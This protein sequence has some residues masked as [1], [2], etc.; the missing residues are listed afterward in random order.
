MPF[1]SIITVTLN[2]LEGLQTTHDSLQKQGFSDFE[3][4]ICD[5]GSTDGTLEFLDTTN[6][7]R[8]SKNDLGIYDAMNK[9]LNAAN[10][11]YLLFL[12]A[13]DALAS[14]TVLQTLHNHSNNA[15]FLYGDA[16]EEVNGVLNTKNAK[17]HKTIKTGMF[18]HHQA[19]LY[20]REALN[21]LTYNTTYQIAADYDFT[22]RFLQ[23]TQN[24][25]KIREA[26]C[27]FESGGISQTKASLGRKEQFQIRKNLKLCSPLENFTITALQAVMWQLRTMFPGFYWRW[28]SSRNSAYGSA[29][30]T[31]QPAHPKS[32]SSK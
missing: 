18:T 6:A 11:Q 7:K 30:R 13:G 15:D 14:N 3:W 17:H 32:L 1:F 9:G 31:V 4:L 5:G 16:Y 26:L 28:K 19:M 27:I 2:T 29:P 8:V 25:Q 23:T 12:N 21:G 10:G 24:I 22:A 20:K